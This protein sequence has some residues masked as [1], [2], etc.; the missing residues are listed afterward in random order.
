M[1]VSYILFIHP[2]FDGHV[3]CLFVLTFMNSAVINLAVYLSLRH[4]DIIPIEHTPNSDISK[5]YDG[6]FNI[7]LILRKLNVFPDVVLEHFESLNVSKYQ[8]KNWDSDFLKFFLII[9]I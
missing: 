8:A 4:P 2:S 6:Y 1:C 7:L 9:I 3:S 5:R